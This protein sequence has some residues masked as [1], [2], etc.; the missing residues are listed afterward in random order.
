MKRGKKRD[1][2]EERREGKRRGRGII[3]EEKIIG[4]KGEEMGRIDERM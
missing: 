3:R 1:K 2:H 4:R